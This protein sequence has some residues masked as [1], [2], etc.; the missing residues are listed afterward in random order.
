MH[1]AHTH[2]RRLVEIRKIENVQ[3]APK[4]AC[5]STC[6]G[7]NGYSTESSS[8]MRQKRMNWNGEKKQ[9]FTQWTFNE[10]HNFLLLILDL[11]ANALLPNTWSRNYA[12][13]RPLNLFLGTVYFMCGVCVYYSFGLQLRIVHFQQ[14]EKY[15]ALR[16]VLRLLFRILWFL[17]CISCIYDVQTL[18]YS[19][20][21]GLRFC[22]FHHY[23]RAHQA[24]SMAQTRTRTR[25]ER[26][27]IPFPFGFVC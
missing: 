19:H 12:H 3:C 9:S 6:Y 15:L 10:C 21:H 7:N 18:A 24:S 23:S 4:C 16:N 11:L 13:F 14:L 20:T 17:F 26:E 25:L 8:S 5:A 22:S 2:T 1:N 27:T